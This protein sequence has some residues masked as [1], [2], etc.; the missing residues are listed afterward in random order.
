MKLLWP[1][2]LVLFSFSAHSVCM[3]E[4]DAQSYGC[5][6]MIG[7]NSAEKWCNQKHGR[8]FKP[9]VTDNVC[10]KQ[11]AAE[12]RGET[13]TEKFDANDTVE[14]SC[15]TYEQGT[16][17]GCQYY[18]YVL[19]SN[20]C[21]MNYGERYLPFIPDSNKCSL[22]A[23]ATSRGEVS[24]KT[25]LS[26]L[27]SAMDEIET[28]MT[29]VDREGMN[30]VFGTLENYRPQVRSEFYTDTVKA[31]MAKMNM[32]NKKMYQ[33]GQSNVPITDKYVPEYIRFSLRYL[34]VLQ[35]LHKVYA[36]VAHNNHVV[37]KTYDYKNLEYLNLK[38]KKEHA[39]EVL[40]I[41]N[42]KAKSANNGKDIEFSIGQQE[43]QTFEYMA[44]EEPGSK[45]DYAKLVTFMGVRETLTNLWGVQRMTP[46]HVANARTKSCGNF[47]SFRPG[48]GGAMDKSDAYQELV[49]YDIFY[50]D[51]VTRWEDLVSESEDVSVLTE[52]SATDLG[53]YVL[54]N[55]SELK[56]LLTDA[57]GAMSA[58]DFRTQASEDAS[59]L[60]AAENNY[61]LE[62]SYGQFSTILMPGDNVLN[63]NSIMDRIAEEAY[64]RRVQAIQSAFVSSYLWISDSGLKDVESKIKWFSDKYLKNDFKT[65]LKGELSKAMRDYNSNYRLAKQN[66]EQKE[67]ETYEAAK[68]ALV[69]VNV[70][71]AIK[72]KSFDFR[73]MKT[74]EPSS[75][76]ELMG[77]FQHRVET[78][79][80]DLKQ[81]LNHNEKLSQLLANF[82][83]ELSESF[84][85]KY[86][87][88]TAD[89]YEL[90]GDET[91]RA[92]GLRQIAFDLA[93]K[94]YSKYPY[95][96]SNYRPRPMPT[97]AQDNTRV[98]SQRRHT[99]PVY[100]DGTAAGMSNEEFLRKLPSKD[101]LRESYVAQRDNT[102]V[103]MGYT[104]PIRPQTDAERRSNPDGITTGSV[105]RPLE[106]D[107]Y[108]MISTQSGRTQINNSKFM[109]MFKMVAENMG[110]SKVAEKMEKTKIP[111]LESFGADQ[112]LTDAKTFFY[113]VFKAL[114]LER[115]GMMNRVS[116]GFAG[117]MNA[118]KILADN[119][120]SEAYQ[121]APIL[122]NELEF[123]R[124]VKKFCFTKTDR[125]YRCDETK[126]YRLPLLEAVA[127]K[128]YD[129]EKGRFDSRHAKSL[130][131]G[132]IDKAI[133]NTSNK[134]SEYCNLNYMNYKNDQD[135]R[136]VFSSS[137]FLR[138][139]VKM[140]LAKSEEAI[141]RISKLDED[142]RKEIRSKWEK[143]NEDILI[144][145]SFALTGIALAAFVIASVV[146]TG[147]AILP[148]IA[149]SLM[150]VEAMVGFAA[151]AFV[152]NAITFNTHF[153][154]VP[155]NL[156][157]QQSLAMS[158]IGDAKVVDWDMYNQ[159]KE[160]NITQQKWTL[161][162]MVLEAAML[163]LA[164]HQVKFDTG[165][166][167]RRAMGRLTGKA[168]K[169]WSSSPRVLR[170]S[171]SF[172]KMVEKVGLKRAMVGKLE[173][174]IQTLRAYQ[175]RY[176]ALPREALESLPLRMGFV[177]KADSINLARK[178]WAML[179]DIESH[180]SKLRARLKVYDEYVAAENA[181][182]KQAKLNGGLKVYE[183]KKHFWKSAA[184]FMP[185]TLFSRITK[186]DARG[187]WNFFMKY[188][189][190]WDELKLLQGKMVKDRADAIDDVAK[191]LKD[192]QKGVQS[193]YYQ[194]D[195]LM[196]Q[197][198]NTISDKE[199]LALEEIARTSKG[200][201][202]H[203]KSV[204]K[205]YKRVTNG[206]KP[207]SYL[208]VYKNQKFGE[209]KYPVSYFLDGK[210]IGAAFK[211]EAD[212]I[213][214]FYE[215]MMKNRAF[216][217]EA[218]DEAREGLEDALSRKIRNNGG[219]V[220]DY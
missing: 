218:I 32:F 165:V 82:F 212:D 177:R 153:I 61:W 117:D 134:V 48:T 174:G 104:K 80:K 90:V 219:N 201:M 147:G 31:L 113:R 70:L 202:S 184:G 44:I 16:K 167:G 123:S 78:S 12:L 100:E 83:K 99:I 119:L 166:I 27:S 139:A 19:A 152:S 62:F 183:L 105:S 66:R 133:D 98:A 59:M 146:G 154:E 118:Q 7:N 81:T 188:D 21:S 45:R 187:V 6:S 151:V 156:K 86:I 52:R 216:K 4:L 197:F 170:K 129:R 17:R 34:G 140:N 127:F 109:A 103:Y 185:K 195:D 198:L 112:A 130:I 157:F 60:I 47:L 20:Y 91:K 181:V 13:Y 10:S 65:R 11:L 149:G 110:M 68:K 25:L 115:V 35:R 189:E 64:A 150:T 194:G 200:T 29:M 161:A 215:S 204:F 163:P 173:Q 217:S 72:N 1:L 145:G 128:A 51:Y 162:T 102:N 3:T 28:V 58:D 87:R 208:N 209:G 89:G 9:Y 168:L 54:R 169:G 120:V 207:L 106:I 2:L 33:N 206:L 5:I 126:Q 97:V 141:E 41:V 171:P 71:D 144:P 18:D 108:G 142:I 124:T 55:V 178:P 192:F 114:S 79:F 101:D 136:K 158:Q 40:A 93:K 57:M 199:I 148:A 214:N 193:G 43:L 176:Q 203:F 190:V 211:G 56:K 22:S 73:E 84:N 164:I 49:E 75:P 50:N 160:E 15:M 94:Y 131:S 107:E 159:D 191:K 125:A 182:V 135:F 179:D 14:A 172:K 143:F 210:D 205:D 111:G 132:T 95:K 122:R 74:L 26:G 186:L 121:A 213:V 38:L 88:Q 92:Q 96:L 76:Q 46:N 175:P 138:E 155:A 180:S 63:K 30:S 69:A 23:A 67:K 37:L 196:N 8:K 85:K 116:G 53:D 137:K 77:L 24:G 36:K 42:Y 39:L 220:S